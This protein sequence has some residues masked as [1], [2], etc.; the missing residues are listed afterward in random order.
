MEDLLAGQAARALR[1][2]VTPNDAAAWA[3]TGSKP[4]WIVGGGQARDV[5]P[6]TTTFEP[7]AV[8]HR[9]VEHRDLHGVEH[10]VVAVPAA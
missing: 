3:S 8:G 7:R 2:I 4:F 6:H 1:V 10:L 5:G 9:D